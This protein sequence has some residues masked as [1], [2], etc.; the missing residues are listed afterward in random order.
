[1]LCANTT[2]K[3]LPIGWVKFAVLLFLCSAAF[4]TAYGSNYAS[5]ENNQASQAQAAVRKFHQDYYQEFYKHLDETQADFP[6]IMDIADRLFTGK[7]TTHAEIRQIQATLNNKLNH[8]YKRQAHWQ[9]ELGSKI[10]IE[11]NIKQQTIQLHNI[12]ISQYK[13]SEHTSKEACDYYQQKALKIYTGLLQVVTKA[14][15][16]SPFE[17]IIDCYNILKEFTDF[18]IETNFNFKV[19]SD[20]NGH[21]QWTFYNPQDAKKINALANRLSKTNGKLQVLYTAIKDLNE[22]IEQ[23]Y[24]SDIS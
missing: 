19:A 16:K 22:E 8:L 13:L 20:H 21:E 14:N 4:V 5:T 9:K 15:T 10:I 7:V 11:N 23:L 3:H 2:K 6:E 24:P 17:P 12:L 18:C 1:L